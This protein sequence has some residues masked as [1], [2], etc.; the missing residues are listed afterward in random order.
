MLAVQEL[1]E[2]KRPI[3]G[4]YIVGKHWAF[5]VLEGTRYATSKSFSCDDEEIFDIYRILRSLR[6]QIEKLL[7]P[8]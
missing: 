8:A 7:G 5:M 2:V 6:L 4:C 3:Y 1:N